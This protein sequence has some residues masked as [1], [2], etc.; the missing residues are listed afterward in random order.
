MKVD[1]LIIVGVVVTVCLNLPAQSKLS[2][3]DSIIALS[4]TGSNPLFFSPFQYGLSKI[5]V[6]Q[7]NQPTET[8]VR[9]GLPNIFSKIAL[10]SGNINIGFIGGSITRANDQYRGQI[11]DYLQ[12][13]Y[14]KVT[15]N[16]INAGVS[17]TG[18]DL[19]AFRIQEQLLDYEP[20]LVFVEFA[21]NGGSNE[22]M[23]GLVRQI[24]AHNSKTDIC[25]IYT[26][27]GS[28]TIN[29][30][31]GDM[32]EK[33]KSF[34]AVARYY[35]IP[36]IHLGMYPAQLEK[37]G[38][39]VWKGPSGSVPIAFSTDGTHPNREGGDL[40]AGAIARGFIKIQAFNGVFRTGLPAKMYNSDWNLGRMYNASAIL[41]K[42]FSE[43]I[44]SGNPDFKQFDSWFD[45]LRVVHEGQSFSFE[46]EGS[47]FGLFDIG[48]PEA[49]ALQFEIDEKPIKLIMH[50]NIHFEYNEA[51]SV[52]QVNRF[53][54]FCNN[55]YRGQ[56][57]WI[58]IPNGKHFITIRVVK[59]HINK[60]N[61]LGP[62]NLADL[63]CR[64]AVYA[65]N[66]LMI[67]RILIRGTTMKMISAFCQQSNE[68]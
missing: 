38:N 52:T 41:N 51:G 11:L 14:P 56:F 10:N 13:I 15:F 5:T 40:Y 22:A 31:N 19:G 24:I 23:E 65:I 25:F 60:A 63:K 1:K 29:Y 35:N 18:T 9:N 45:R 55:R 16:G 53:N 7:F 67:G 17:G 30:Q 61:I 59:S 28:Q 37:D 66:D 68:N 21:V 36:S 42:C 46:F 50:S 62:A 47:G 26:I 6:A 20:D 44:C 49:G 32:P 4:Q 39:I 48:G 12:R 43:I 3:T 58:D 64:P 57:F 34:E 54:Q 33:V 8:T 2:V 27:I